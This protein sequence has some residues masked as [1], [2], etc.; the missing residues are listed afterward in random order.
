VSDGA[1]L[2]WGRP[3]L[4]PDLP[5]AVAQ[6]GLDPTLEAHALQHALRRAIATCR[7]YCRWDVDRSP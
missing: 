2:M 5:G 1:D 3:R 7:G 6:A 4:A